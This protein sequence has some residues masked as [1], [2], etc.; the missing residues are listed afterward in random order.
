MTNTHEAVLT[1]NPFHRVL[2]SYPPTRPF[3]NCWS[4]NTYPDWFDAALNEW[5]LSSSICCNCH[6]CHLN[7]FVTP[8]MRLCYPSSSVTCPSAS[9]QF[10][11]FMQAD[12]FLA[13]TRCLW[14]S[15]GCQICIH[16]GSKCSM[17]H[18]V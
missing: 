18:G 14:I 13:T 12:A 4:L 9:V 5:T 17:R 6:P 1:G 2:I 11:Y 10:E 7:G 8:I 16:V 3:S 15:G